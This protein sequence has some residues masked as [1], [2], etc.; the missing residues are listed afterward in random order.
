MGK[1]VW[2]LRFWCAHGDV[3]ILPD[4]WTIKHVYEKLIG[5]YRDDGL[6][7]TL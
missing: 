5:L 6:Y 1:K 3:R 4:K 7:K 2:Q